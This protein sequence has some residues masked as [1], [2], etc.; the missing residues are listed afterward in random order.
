MSKVV[1]IV[2][3]RMGATRLPGKPLKAVLGKP[4]L[5]YLLDRLKRV[6]KADEIIV[7]TTDKPQDYKIVEVC[8]EEKIPFFCGSEEDVLDRY[9]QTAKKSA[10]DVVVRVTGDC[11]LI[12]PE[13]IDQ[14]I[15]FFLKGGFDYACNTLERTFPRG[16]DVEVFSFAALEKAEK[17]AKAPEEREHVT[18]FFYRQP[19]VF[20]LG[21]F[22]RQDN[23]AR[24]RL[25]VDTQEDLILITLLL[26]RL[27]PEKKDFSLEDILRVLQE[28]PE[29][30]RINANVPQKPLCQ[31]P[32]D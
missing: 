28:N 10:A 14:V 17:E 4:L 13:I 29:W 2:Q 25:T 22:T 1:I 9:Y 23:Q 12:D 21:G 15:H 16:M 32:E 3:A 7:A 24:H 5:A 19:E 26:E 18:P 11:P 31:C 30:E 20:K 27:I 6:K 8:Q